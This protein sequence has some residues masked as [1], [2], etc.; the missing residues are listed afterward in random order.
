MKQKTV[1]YIAI[2]FIGSFVISII[3]GIGLNIWG[4]SNIFESNNSSDFSEEEYKEYQKQEMLRN[5]YNP[6]V[7]SLLDA[8]PRIAAAY[9]DSVLIRY[10]S[11]YDMAFRQGIAYHRIDSLEKAI[12]SYQK[13][14]DINGG[15]YPQALQ[16][17]GF[18]LSDLKKYD[19]A[20]VQFEKASSISSGYENEL[21]IAENYELKGDTEEA[22]RYYKLFLSSLEANNLNLRYW[23][24]IRD[25]K[26]KITELE[27][28][29][30]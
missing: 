22:I 14:M 6:L 21:Y 20:I 24:D 3:S 7:D 11:E 25:L 16:Y 4:L 15:E 26:K 9:I 29:K 1:K 28:T 8:N 27:I 2:I 10:P 19:E 13:A 23:E 18:A 12:A 17:I 5:Y 30:Q